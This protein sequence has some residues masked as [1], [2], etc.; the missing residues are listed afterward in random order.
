MFVS[1]VSVSLYICCICS[2]LFV[3]TILGAGCKSVVLHVWPMLWYLKVVKDLCAKYRPEM[4]MNSYRLA[5]QMGELICVLVGMSKRL[6]IYVSLF[7][8]ALWS[9]YWIDIEMYASCHV[10]LFPQKRETY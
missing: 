1:G 8:D 7:I 9:E 5:I 6:S 2:V 4:V 10:S 3:C